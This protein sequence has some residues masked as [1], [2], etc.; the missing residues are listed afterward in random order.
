MQICIANHFTGKSFVKKFVSHGYTT[1]TTAAS[2]TNKP[3]PKEL[4][5]NLNHSALPPATQNCKQILLRVSA[6]LG[7]LQATQCKREDISVFRLQL[8]ESQI[9]SGRSR[10]WHGRNTESL[11]HSA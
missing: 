2:N 4:K 3:S 6:I 5:P 1:V 8:A 9:T 7:I 10:A 11:E